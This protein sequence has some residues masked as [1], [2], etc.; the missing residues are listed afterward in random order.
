MGEPGSI[1]SWNRYIHFRTNNLGK[2]RN[3]LLRPLPM[4][5]LVGLVTVNHYYLKE[6]LQ[7][8]I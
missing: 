6:I 4:D 8:V 1:S 5:L 7:S 2:V 3:P